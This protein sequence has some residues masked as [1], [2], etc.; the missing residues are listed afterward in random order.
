MDPSESELKD[1]PYIPGRSNRGILGV[2]IDLKIMSRLRWGVL[3]RWGEV[4]VQQK[5][6]KP[7]ASHEFTTTREQRGQRGQKFSSWIFG[8]IKKMRL[9]IAA[10]AKSL[11]ASS[12]N[13]EKQRSES[14]SH[15]PYGTV[16]AG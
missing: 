1:F 12:V 5:K 4:Q 7:S 6:N 13:F 8:V 3:T 16:Q 15:W 9:L 10:Q 11:K 14:R 2:E